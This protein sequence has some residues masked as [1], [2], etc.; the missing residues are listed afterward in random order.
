[1]VRAWRISVAEPFGL[2]VWFDPSEEAVS[3]RDLTPEEKDAR[4]DTD[5]S[6]SALP[7]DSILELDLESEQVLG[8]DLPF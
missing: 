4:V 1:M 5:V 3:I 7:G 2:T 6:V 8:E